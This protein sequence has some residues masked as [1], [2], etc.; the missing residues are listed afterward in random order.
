[1]TL[2]LVNSNKISFYL[3]ALQFLAGQFAFRVQFTPQSQS[4]CHSS[5]HHS[6]I[7]QY[8]VGEKVSLLYGLYH[9]GN[10]GPSWEDPG[11]TISI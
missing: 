7:L 2:E 8:T 4:G 3:S 10:L 6:Q 1:M 11:S 9:G 5:R